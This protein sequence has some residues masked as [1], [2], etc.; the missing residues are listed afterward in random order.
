[1]SA[2]AFKT[3]LKR[4]H[5]ALMVKVL[6]ILEGLELAYKTPPTEKEVEYKLIQETLKLCAVAIVTGSRL[7]DAAQLLR[8]NTIEGLPEDWTLA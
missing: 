3:R 8:F 7:R 5:V 1:M 4:P 2:Q 6:T